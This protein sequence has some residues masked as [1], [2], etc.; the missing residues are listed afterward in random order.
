MR[1]MLVVKDRFPKEQYERAFES[2]WE[3][4]WQEHRDVSKVEVMREC[5]GQ[6]FNS[7]EVADVLQKATE[8]K[9][10]KMLVDQTALVVKKGAYGCPWFIVKNK[11]GKEECFFGSDR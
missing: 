2:L 7:D 9:Y 8:P 6:F 5:L 11:E 3:F 10:K 4:Y 1:S